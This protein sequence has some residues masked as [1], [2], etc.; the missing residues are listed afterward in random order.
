MMKRIL[1]AVAVAALGVTA[2]VAQGDPIAARKAVM[3]ENNNQGRIAREMAD[4]KQPFDLAVAKKAFASFQDAA[5]KLPTLFP[6]GSQAGDTRALPAIWEKPA[7]FKA[8]ADK[9]GADAKAGAANIKDVESLKT[10]MAELG[11]N[12]GSCHQSFRKPQS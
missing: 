8:A 12:C 4:G 5:T 10:A 7:E 2:V 3:K 1:L 9:F 11:K 6:A